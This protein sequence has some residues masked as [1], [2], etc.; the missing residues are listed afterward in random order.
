MANVANSYAP[1]CV[2]VAVQILLNNYRGG[3][4]LNSVVKSVKPEKK[5]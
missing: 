5:K 3:D 2:L 4:K 1:L